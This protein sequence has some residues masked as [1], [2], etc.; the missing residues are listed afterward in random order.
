MVS[1][2]ESN[3]CKRNNRKNHSFTV[4]Y[5]NYNYCEFC[6]DC[7]ALGGFSISE[8]LLEHLKEERDAL[9]AEDVE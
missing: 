8:D 9:V 4:K 3:E 6:G 1:W 5:K 7:Q 2:E